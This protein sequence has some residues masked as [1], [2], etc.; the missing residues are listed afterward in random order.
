MFKICIAAAVSGYSGFVGILLVGFIIDAFGRKTTLLLMLIPQI[1]GWTLLYSDYSAF[2]AILGRAFTGLTT[3]A[4]FYPPQLYAVECITVNH[5][6]LRS[7]FRAWPGIT[8]SIGFLV[9]FFLG[10]FFSYQLVCAFAVLLSAIIFVL[11]FITIPES[12]T[13]LY[14]KGRYGDAEI[15]E[16]KLG[17]TQPILETI[18]NS[19]TLPAPRIFGL[20]RS[21]MRQ[22]VEKLVRSDVYTPVIVMSIVCFLIFQTGGTVLSSYMLDVIGIN[23]SDISASE[24]LAHQYSIVSALLI[25]IAHTFVS[26][27]LPYLGCKKMSITMSF[28]MCIGMVILG[29]TTNDANTTDSYGLHVVAVWV[30]LFSFHFGVLSVPVAVMSDLFPPDAKGFACIPILTMSLSGAFAVQLYP[31]LSLYFVGGVYYV[32]AFVCI[33]YA[34]F[35]FY[36][37][38]ETVARTYEQV[39]N[40]LLRSH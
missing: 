10:A 2:I 35:V 33:I 19:N 15:S 3:V 6:R 4:M 39:R 40:H 36:F 22:V 12:P 8:N 30:V 21:S 17:I 7:N 1:I 28:F 14:M 23:P 29:M 5:E 31:Y 27:T 37:M 32:Y 26:L 9:I 18:S 34:A 20:S 11:I 16:R 24:S 13:W 25:L 38:P